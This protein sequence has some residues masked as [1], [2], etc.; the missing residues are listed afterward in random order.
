MV[1]VVIDVGCGRFSVWRGLRRSGGGYGCVRLLTWLWWFSST[2]R[3]RSS[4][5]LSEEMALACD[6][7]FCD[8]SWTCSQRE[9]EEKEERRR[10]S[11][12]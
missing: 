7:K 10:R 11:R 8:R 3:R 4:L 2:A 6:G 1:V 5:A 12:V 9:G